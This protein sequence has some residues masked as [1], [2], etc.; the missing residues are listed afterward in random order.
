MY[1]SE[2]RSFC[3]LSLVIY[4]DLIPI[5]IVQ[6]RRRCYHDTG[7]GLYPCIPEVFRGDHSC[8]GIVFQPDI[9]RTAIARRCFGFFQYK[10]RTDVFL[11]Q[12]FEVD[13]RPV[14]CL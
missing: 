8:F 1:N 5:Y 2:N 14:I 12:F 6:I 7:I 3:Q 4:L 9:L 10:V 11:I 13:G